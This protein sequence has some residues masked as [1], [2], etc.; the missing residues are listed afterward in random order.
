MSKEKILAAIEALKDADIAQQEVLPSD[1]S[2]ELHCLLE[3]AMSD[4][5]EMIED[6]ERPTTKAVDIF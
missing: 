3:S 5:E 4:M 6:L 2:Y 1:Q